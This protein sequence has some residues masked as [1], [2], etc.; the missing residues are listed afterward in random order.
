MKTQIMGYRPTSH[1]AAQHQWH[2]AP[3]PLPWLTIGSGLT[4]FIVGFVAT[5]AVLL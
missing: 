5:L 2:R 4:A 3:A 1:A